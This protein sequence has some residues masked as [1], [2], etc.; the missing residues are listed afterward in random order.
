MR[1]KWLIMAAILFGGWALL[2][3]MLW[4]SD[5]GEYAKSPQH[6]K[7]QQGTTAIVAGG[8][9]GVVFQGSPHRRRAEILIRCKN[10]EQEIRLR[11]DELSEE[12]CGIQIRFLDLEVN[13]R[14]VVIVSWQD[15]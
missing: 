1:S 13:G 12:V 11:R 6:L 8:R 15:R 4:S 10:V 7:L 9:A 14:A 5:L 2:E 3:F